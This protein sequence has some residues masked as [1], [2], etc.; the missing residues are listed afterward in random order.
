VGLVHDEQADALDEQR[1]HPLAELRVVQ[2]LG[3]DQQEVDRV[4]VELLAD[5]I[6]VVAVRRVDRH[7]ADA[8][9][10]GGGDLV[11]HE[12]EE[13]ADEERR[14]RALTP[15]QRGGEE[16]HRALAPAGALHAEDAAAIGHQVADGLEL[17]F[18]ERRLRSRE[19]AQERQGLGFE[20]VG[21]RGRH[22]PRI[23]PGPARPPGWS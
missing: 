5:G 18:S 10:P 1:Q 20:R 13:R 12:R 17:V 8:E 6:P 23:G 21:G 4:G 2:A 16:V 15:Q 19:L 11:A 22:G 9:P 14:A 3:A 7:R